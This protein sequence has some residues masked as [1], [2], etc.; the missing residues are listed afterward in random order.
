MEALIVKPTKKSPSI[1][2]MDGQ[3]NFSGCSIINDPKDF[4]TPVLSWIKDYVKNPVDETEINIQ[5]EYIDSASVKTFFDIL[6]ELEKLS[7]KKKVGINWY[8][9][10]EDPEILELGEILQSKLKMDF[11]FVEE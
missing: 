5:F 8:F 4:F 2:L 9:S 3:L 11:K 1:N 6:K 7:R 10:V